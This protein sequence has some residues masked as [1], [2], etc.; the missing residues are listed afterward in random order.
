MQLV[1]TL[2][3]IKKKAEHELSNLKREIEK[4]RQEKKTLIAAIKMSAQESHV[5]QKNKK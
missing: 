4:I 2:T 5:L 3:S 1:N